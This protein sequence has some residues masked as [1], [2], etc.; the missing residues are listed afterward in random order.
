M[1]SLSAV[2]YLPMDATRTSSPFYRSM[3]AYENG[4]HAN[5]T[6]TLLKPDS[7]FFRFFGDPMG[8]A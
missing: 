3:Q 8:K 7:E 4:L 2:K 1:R 5:D 6:R